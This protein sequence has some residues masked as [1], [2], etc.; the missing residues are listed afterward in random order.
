VPRSKITENTIFLTVGGAASVVF[1]IIQLSILSRSMSENAFGLFVALRGF[2]LLLGTVMLVGL[3]QVLVRFLPSYQAR[4]AP[5][6]AIAVFLASSAVVIVIGT[7]LYAT[8]GAWAGV[9]PA[10]MRGLIPSSAVLPWVVL[11]SITL[12]L[13]MLL[14]GGFN[15][16][17]E[18]RFQTLFECAFL[19]I[20]TVYIVGARSRLE[21]GSL[22]EVMFIVNGALFVVGIP[23]YAARVSRL[24]RA[25]AQARVDGVVLPS[26]STYWIGS[27]ALSVV[28]LAFSDVDRF[29]MSSVLPMAAVSL[30]HVASRVDVLI[31]RFLGLPILAAQPEITRVYEEGRWG[32]IA[33]RIGLFTKG[34]LV[35]ALFCVSLFAVIGKAVIIVLSGKT[36]VDSYPIILI[37]LPTVPLAAVAAPLLATMRSLHFMRWA[38]LCDFLWM[39]MYFGTFFFFVSVIGVR[40]MAV[41]Q[42]VASAVQTSAAILLARREKFFGGVGSGLGAPFVAIVI[43][44]AAGMLVTRQWGVA[45]SAAC[46]ALAPLAAKL[47]IKRLGVFEP[48]EARQILAIVTVPAG[49]RVLAWLLSAGER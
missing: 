17:R 24:M 2:S 7:A 31:K 6:R 26:L 36:Y 19:A 14:Y 21:V 45:A 41:A 25:A 9:I 10:R 43:L 48:D 27:I 49:R 22:F 28:A 38:V 32:D 12:A 15:G 18:M 23:I 16:L 5:R 44:T 3:P 35:A 20:F 42:L 8:S 13:K 30:F 46:L 37:L 47:I 11:S 29:V 40:G 39:V 4:R 1:T 34:M 33:G